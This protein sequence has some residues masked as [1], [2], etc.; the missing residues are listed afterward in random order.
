[1]CRK[2]QSARIHP[3]FTPPVHTECP[4]CSHLISQD[5]VG[6]DGEAHH[7]GCT[8]LHSTETGA[9]QV[10]LVQHLY[11]CEISME[12]GRA[13]GN[14]MGRGALGS[15][16]GVRAIPGIISTTSTTLCTSNSF[17]TASNTARCRPFKLGTAPVLA[18]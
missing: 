14:R 7:E 4:R 15:T 6:G 16:Y 9:N 13:D 10:P 12:T 3:L 18:K 17:S 11:K 1:M 5:A 2:S 8:V